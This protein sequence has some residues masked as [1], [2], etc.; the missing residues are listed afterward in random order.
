M[1][2]F[3]LRNDHGRA[4]LITDGTSFKFYYLRTVEEGHRIYRANLVAEEHLQTIMGIKTFADLIPRTPGS[5]LFG[6][7][8]DS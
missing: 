6:I 4:G 1:P 2:L 7:C 3:T 5:L 8:S